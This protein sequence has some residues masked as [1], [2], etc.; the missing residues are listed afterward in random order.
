MANKLKETGFHLRLT[1]K[2]LFEI[3]GVPDEVLHE[4]STRRMDIWGIWMRRVGM[5]QKVH[6][7]LLY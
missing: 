3:D 5:V 1:G 7:L 6:P 4:F 2:G